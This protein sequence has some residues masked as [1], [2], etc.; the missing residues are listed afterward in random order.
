MIAAMIALLFAQD[1]TT[2]SQQGAEAMRAKRYAEAE[3]VYRKLVQQDKANPMW[4]M[5]LGLA[6]HS[7]GRFAEAATE[8]DVFVKARPAPGPAHLLLGTAHL[9]LRKACEAVSALEKARAWNPALATLELADAY[10]GC[11]QYLKAAKAYEAAPKPTAAV[12][13]QA[14]HCY[15]QARQYPDARRLYAVV[16][17]AFDTDAAFQYEYGDTLARA[18]GAA[19]GLPFLQRAHALQPDFLPARGELGKALLAVGRAADAVSHLEAAAA[20]DTALLLPLANALRQVGRGAEADQA[21]A[22][23]RAR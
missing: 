16:A 4:R 14:A 21:L 19:R 6:L 9:K 10:Y 13:R 22:R 23:Y 2:L 1:V 18:E 11:Q 20:A 8:L 15:W 3:G 12:T 17:A 7:S 5:N